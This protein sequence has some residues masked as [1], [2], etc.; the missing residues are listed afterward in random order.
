MTAP[1]PVDRERRERL[2]LAAVDAAESFGAGEFTAAD[3]LVLYDPAELVEG[4]ILY[5]QLMQASYHIATSAPL[6]EMPAAARQTAVQW[7][8]LTSGGT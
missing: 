6:H 2:T 7:R 8:R 4:L 3:L 1:P 5:V